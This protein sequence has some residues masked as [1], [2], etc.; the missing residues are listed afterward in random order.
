MR[1]KKAS[2]V[3]ISKSKF[4]QIEV[5]DKLT[6]RYMIGKNKVTKA[7]YKEKGYEYVK[8]NFIDGPWASKN[9]IKLIR[10]QIISIN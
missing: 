9:E 4:E 10:Q 5:G 7:P 6:F 8:V 2:S 3:W 1:K